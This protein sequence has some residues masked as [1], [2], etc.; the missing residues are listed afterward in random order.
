VGADVVGD[1]VVNDVVVGGGAVVVFDRVPTL[2]VV[3]VSG[4]G[5]PVMTLGFSSV[6]TPQAVTTTARTTAKARRIMQ[7]PPGTR[8]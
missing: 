2:G 8:R 5:T 4:A 1:V 7:K 3:A 6:D